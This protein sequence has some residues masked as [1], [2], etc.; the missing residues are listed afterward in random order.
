MIKNNLILSFLF[1]AISLGTSAQSSVQSG[2]P[3]PVSLSNI[4]PYEWDSPKIQGVTP[5]GKS[6]EEKLFKEALERGKQPKDYYTLINED[7]K[8]VDVEKLMNYCYKL[9]YTFKKDYKTKHI[10]KFGS[11]VET[12]AEFYFLPNDLYIFYVFDW[13]DRKGVISSSL[14]QKGS[15]YFYVPSDNNFVVLNDALWSGN[16][17]NGKIDGS[18]SG[19][20]QKDPKNY[21][22]FSGTFKNGIPQGEVTHRIV[23]LDV[24]NWGYT[25]EEARKNNH[26]S[27]GIDYYNIKVGD[28]SEG[29]A[30]YT[31]PG[32]DKYGIL[33]SSNGNI[34]IALKPTYKSFVSDFQN[35]KATV[36]RGDEEIII[37]Q[38]GDF[39]DLTTKQKRKN[40]L[41]A[42]EQKKKELAQRQE[43][44]ERER[45]AKEAEK[46][47]IEKFRNAR[48]GDRV[49]YSQE[50][51][52]GGGWFSPT[53]YYTMRV[54]CFVEQNVDNGERLQI[55]VG[56]VESSN[57]SKY[58]TPEID[59]IKYHKGDVL[60]IKPLYDKGWQIE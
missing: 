17:V 11:S 52:S 40:E 7:N 31:A 41:K 8:S 13:T 46:R 30:Y 55:R 43:Q 18:G 42:A 37:N 5:K 15:V 22:Y 34:K 25:S 19:I 35:G 1:F 20:F 28:W 21:Y 4:F 10:K 27:G 47:R 36:M 2:A 44:I 9:N 38:Y 29:L 14:K 56:S 12:V 57:S 48:P 49:F 16:V 26:R 54:T 24:S 53:T 60:W 33:S 58:S 6:N 50:W 45:Q 59:G 39:V 3:A 51:R 23:N 32:N